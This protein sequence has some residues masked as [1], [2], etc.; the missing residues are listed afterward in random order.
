M[1]EIELV[2]KMPEETVNAIKDNAMFAKDIADSIKWDITSAIVNGAPLPK[3]HGRLIDEDVLKNQFP[4]WVDNF[5][6]YGVNKTI[7]KTP[8]IIDADK[9]EA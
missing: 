8:T 2:I 5:S 4:I 9:E 7:S 6:S 1:A 3:K